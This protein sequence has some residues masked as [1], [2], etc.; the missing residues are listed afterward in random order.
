[1]V[2][3]FTAGWTWA[4][5]TSPERVTNGKIPAPQQG[6]LAPDFSLKSN[7][8]NSIKLSD[9]RGKVVVVNIWA[10]WCPPCKAEMPA[11]E[12][13]FTKYQK[14]GLVILGVN[15]TIQDN[16]GEA[17]SFSQSLGLSFPVLFDTSGEVT[18]LYQVHALPTSFFIDSD[19]V[20]RDIVIGG[21]MSEASLDA[22]VR[23]LLG[24]LP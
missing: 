2:L 1:M 6:F 24:G 15:S 22:R 14:E 20:I 7:Q 4:S 9:L 8:G 11:L 23:N 5:A 10:S 18:H 21:P 17:I 3:L 13:V 19:G 16:T 12:H